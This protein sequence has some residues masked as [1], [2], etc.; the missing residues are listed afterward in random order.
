MRSTNSFHT[1]ASLFTEAGERKYLNANER[2]RFYDALAFMDDPAERSFCKLIYWTGCRI[3]EA[4]QVTQEHI[5]VEA[6]TVLIRSLKKH[7]RLKGKHYRTLH[8]PRDF[9]G[10]LSTVPGLRCQSSRHLWNF[11]RQKGWRLIKEA[12]TH[13]GVY[14]PR[15]SARGLRHGFGV[16]AILSGVPETTLQRWLGHTSLETTAIYIAVM[17]A[18]ERDIARRMW[19]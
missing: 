13:A 19:A 1:E 17:G 8:V 11:T 5:D 16:H 15:A 7:G 10:E 6:G 12:M 9:V 4:L 14:G 2:Q 18:E 3:S